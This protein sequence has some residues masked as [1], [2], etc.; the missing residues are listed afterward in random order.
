[1]KVSDS[2]SICR[3]AIV[4]VGLHSS[5]TFAHH[6]RAE[7][8]D[9]VLVFEGEL[10]SVNWANPHPT[11]AV[12][13]ASERW[14]VQAFGSVYT[15]ARGGVS[16]DVF[17]PGTIVRIAGQVS[18]R[19]DK[20]LLTSNM[21]LASGEEVVLNGGADT[22]WNDAGI[23][24]AANWAAAQSDLVDARAENRGLF[25]VWSQ[26]HRDGAT[27]DS[28]IEGAITLHVPYNDV[29]LARR[30]KWDPLDDP[31]MQCMPKG[32][33]AVMVTPHP[34][35]FSQDGPN[36]RIVAH[37]YD[38]ERIIY[39]EDPPD[40]ETLPPQPVGFSVG[41]WEGDTLVV[42]TT[43][44]AWN[45]FF[46]GFGLGDNVEVVERIRLSEDQSRLDYTAAFTDPETFTEPARIERYW[47]A[48]GE[49]PAPYTCTPG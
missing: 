12:D 19:R 2:L 18:T 16:G 7:F 27:A 34:F 5:G 8:S 39:M 23:G 22:F 3:I 24:G 38:V 36:I 45:Y 49:T 14:E 37:E 44:I 25:R 9:E 33:P 30:A 32:M 28:A 31:D 4:I 42:E 15:L 21:L 40:P 29:A 26:P 48:L 1:M 41:R 13:I 47:L 17:M 46:F 43:D 6:S 11:F 10:L 35:T 20:L